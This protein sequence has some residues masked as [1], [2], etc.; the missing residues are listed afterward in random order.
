DFGSINTN[1]NIF[2]RMARAGVRIQKFHPLRPWECK[3]SWRPVNRDHRKIFLIDNNIAGLGG[4]NVATEYAGSWVVKSSKPDSDFWRDCAVGI[5]GPG[6]RV[7]WKAFA[8]TWNYLKN[9]GPIGRTELIENVDQ[10]ELG[11][12]ASSPT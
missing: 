1:E 11:C 12:M 9:G 5:R 10:G 4:L 6:S 7:F 2:R 8:H 3:Y